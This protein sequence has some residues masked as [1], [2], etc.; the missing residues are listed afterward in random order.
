MKNTPWTYHI[1]E[2]YFTIYNSQDDEV[3][4]TPCL[5]DADAPLLTAIVQ[6]V[7]NHDELVAALE[8]AR[9]EMIDPNRGPSGPKGVIQIATA[10]LNATKEGK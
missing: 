1:G 2:D 9:L 10:A 5:P 7:N 4:T 8:A 6:A 3:L